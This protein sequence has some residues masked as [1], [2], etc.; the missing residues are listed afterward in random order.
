MSTARVSHLQGRLSAGLHATQAKS[1][2][3]PANAGRAGPGQLHA[4]ANT[5]RL[6]RDQSAL[7]MSTAMARHC[8]LLS[9]QVADGPK[10]V[11]ERAVAQLTLAL[12]SLTWYALS[13]QMSA[14][15]GTD[16]WTL[17]QAIGC[18]TSHGLALGHTS[19]PSFTSA[20]PSSMPYR[21]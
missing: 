21:I 10:M 14:A 19:G 13:L 9:G 8:C 1:L 16:L 17:E 2:N 12:S 5:H 4:E 15:L 18:S 6:T 11:H 7:A 20:Y 3:A